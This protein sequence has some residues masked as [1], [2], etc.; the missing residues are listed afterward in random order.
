MRW[1]I[2]VVTDNKSVTM[3]K[4]FFILAFILCTLAFPVSVKAQYYS[5]NVDYRTVAEMSAAFN[6][7]AAT[8]MYYAEQI[9]KIRES[10]Q[11]AEV[12]AAGIFASKFLDRKALT[13]LGLW[14]S[15][16]ENYYYRRIY[17]MVSAKI[18]PKIWTVAGMMLKNPQNALYW[19]TYL[20][21]VCD[22][23]KNL[24]YQFESIVTNSSLSFR[25]IAFL[26]IN[27]EIA[28]IL[29]LSELGNTDW[30]AIL[31]NF[32]NISGN[33]S[34]ENLKADIDNL[35]QMGVNLASAGA[36]NLAQSILEGS[37]FNGSIG[38]KVGSIITIADNVSTLY[39]SL[40]QS[41]G[42]T[43]LGLVGG[44]EG[45]ANL[46]NLSNYNTTAWLTDYAREGM[47]QYYTQR[48]YIYRVDA[49]SVNLC[50]YYP[51]TD[52]NSILYGDHWYRIDTTDPN[53]YPTSAQREAALQNSEA[54]AGWSRSRVQQLNNSNDGNTYTINYWSNAYILSKSKSGQYAKAYAYEIHVTKS[55]YRKEEMYEDV[56]DSYTMDLNTFK[57]GLNARLTELND[58][59]EGYTYYLGSDSKR[60]YQTTNAQKLEGCETATISVTCH[61]GAKLGEGSTQYKCSSCGGSVNQH[62][63]QCVM[64]TSVSE[65]PVGTSEIDSQINDTQNHIT[66]IQNQITALDNENAELLKKI[67]T[68]SVEDAARYRQQYNSN[69]DKISQLKSELATWQSQLK[70]LQQAKQ[71]AEEGE[72][73][74]TDDYYRIPAIMQ[75]CKSAYNLTWND[76]GSWSGNTFIRTA[77]MPN[78]N[79]VITFKA[80]VSIARKPKYFLGIK[81][82][83]AIVQISWTLTTEYSDTQVVAV[84]NLDPDK[85]DQEK[86]DEVNAKLAEV[87]RSYPECDTS[88]EY[89]KSDPVETDD[90]DDT[91]HLLWSSD[92]LEIARDIDT[93]L[94]K[95]Y[96]DLV[97]LEKMMHYKHS[98]IDMLK[99][100]APYINDEQG[101]KLTLI[102]QCRKRWLRHAANSAHS[103]GYNGKYDEEDEE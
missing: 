72:N 42:N 19:G 69:K 53:F 58:N 39:N 22:E 24:C 9:A 35:Y 95:I 38:D 73:V 82:H 74:R 34:K 70:D 46:F 8:E 76:G 54:H 23:T 56:F 20:Y 16:T 93:R 15:S 21:K 5:V 103:D 11:A 29:K 98:I 62:T 13:D 60:Y 36:G 84:L 79:G 75:D 14:T 67:S 102:E 17:N 25:D 18:M 51:P 37:N 77:S 65:A 40:D 64:A 32:S 43:L 81:I 89:A 92:R 4:S 49:G 80:T 85:S 12:A 3:Y 66:Q 59:E 31:D 1:I 101:R 33:F 78:I 2:G 52:D 44:E 61:D 28:S 26:E 83:R 96:A 27:Q 6:T 47:G 94:T 86:A 30:K 50:D 45:L 91:Y 7:E 87:A 55:W 71:E 99:A 41:V 57:A 90:T 97:S 88:V 100:A 10:Y 48:W 63:K 68:S